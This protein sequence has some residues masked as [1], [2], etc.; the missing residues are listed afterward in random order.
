MFNA[1][2]TIK[3]CE[4]TSKTQVY[5]VNYFYYQSHDSRLKHCTYTEEPYP[6]CTT[7]S[8]QRARLAPLAVSVDVKA[9]CTEREDGVPHWTISTRHVLRIY[10]EENECASEFMP[11]AQHPTSPSHNPLLSLMI[12]CAPTSP[13]SLLCQSSVFLLACMNTVLQEFQS[14]KPLTMK[15]LILPLP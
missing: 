7:A 10:R 1:G 15:P 8:L 11:D 6:T 4:L 9:C 2:N 5:A 14:V 3:A 13:T 12:L